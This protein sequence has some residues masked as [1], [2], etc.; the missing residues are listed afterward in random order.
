MS[1]SNVMPLGS[2]IHLAEDDHFSMHSDIKIIV[3]FMPLLT[4]YRY[5]FFGCFFLADLLYVGFVL[6]GDVLDIQR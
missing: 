4:A 6:V 2:A 3:V 1:H 5:G